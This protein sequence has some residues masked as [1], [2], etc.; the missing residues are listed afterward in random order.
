MFRNFHAA[1]RKALG[2]AALAGV[3]IAGGLGVTRP[4]AA[5]TTIHLGLDWGWL[6]YHAPLLMAID[7]G[8]YAEEGL[9]V[10]IEPG[11][12]SAT[13]AI[14]L[15]QGNYDI[16]HINTT[17]AAAAIAKGVPIQVAAV[18]QKKTAASFIGIADRV[19]IDGIDSIRTYKIGSTPGGSDQLSLRIFRA[20][21]G[22]GDQAL[23]VISVD[24][25][26]KQAALL[27]GRID[28]ISGDGFAYA[29]ILRDKGFEPVLF[30]LADHG[31]PLLG[32]GFSVNKAFAEAHPDAVKAFLRATRRGYE[33]A[34]ADVP[35]ACEFVRAKANLPNSQAN[36]ED[37][38]QG[39]LN[40]SEDP[41]ST[42]W[43]RQ[44]DTIWTDLVKTLTDVGEIKGAFQ[45][46]AFYTNAY[47]P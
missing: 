8:Y 26:A 31:V 1:S 47:L 5:E 14:M 41:T 10:E 16:A 40:L 43:G 2:A 44:N 19:K 3:L 33:T 36:C 27:A 30:Q 38:F 46:A 37:Y 18:Y 23:N 4:A 17:N 11:R 12:G 21:N 34:A 9:T 20:E 24:A 39:L 28:L 32:F 15:G 6:P 7:K 45:P 22:L 25:N 42:D 35:A 13:T 29:S